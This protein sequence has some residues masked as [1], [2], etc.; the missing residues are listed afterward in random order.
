MIHVVVEV[1]TTM[2]LLSVEVIWCYLL[3][4][5]IALTNVLHEVPI[6]HRISHLSLILL[7]TFL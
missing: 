2:M 6:V 4:T 7:C 3:L 1:L 5:G